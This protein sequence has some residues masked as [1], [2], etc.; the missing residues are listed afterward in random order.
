[1]FW[2]V[3]V[4]A[5]AALALSL[6]T[7]E[8]QPPAAPESPWDFVAIGL[9]IVGAAGAFFGAG[10]LQGSG[11]ASLTALVPLIG[12]FALLVALVFYEYRAGNPLMPVRAAA[13][14]A[15]VTGIFVALMA[16]ASS[17]G[18]MEL[19][20]LSLQRTT[21]TLHAG[22]L[23]LPE[24]VAAIAI[25][26]LFGALFRS[27]FTPVMAIGGLLAIVGSSAL[28]IVALPSSGWFVYAATGALG[29]G[30][31]A[32][33]SPGLFMAGFSMRSAQLQRVF[34]MIEL[35]RAVTAFLVT[36][37]L[38]YLSTFMGAGTSGGITAALWIC[39]GIASFGFAG[40]LLL[41]LGGKRRLEAPDLERWESEG[42]LAWDSP[43]LFS[44]LR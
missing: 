8:D 22:L 33:V 11:T 39:L 36:P 18:I 15:P 14:T 26:A 34:A 1:L 27:R 10:W 38:V 24:F 17:F 42:E 28:L 43:P 20:L 19:L 2:G 12:G 7:F 44:L 40:G 23:F 3:A 5:V 30:V 16:S 29:L 35:M 9:T 25:A 37:I 41:Y 13:T 31:G 4:V 32:S 21:G 6:L